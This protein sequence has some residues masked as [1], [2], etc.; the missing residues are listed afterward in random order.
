ML[1][2]VG[3]VWIGFVVLDIFG[4]FE[5][6]FWRFGVG[7]VWIFCIVVVCLDC[8]SVDFFEGCGCR[9]VR[10]LIEIYVG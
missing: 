10:Y 6:G 5:V 8:K 1:C 4:Y 2:I 9:L 7:C 3:V